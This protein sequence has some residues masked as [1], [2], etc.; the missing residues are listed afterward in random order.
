MVIDSH[1]KSALISGLASGAILI[2]ASFF[3]TGKIGSVLAK[4][5]N[6][7]LLGVFGWRS[8][9]AIA[10]LNN[11]LEGKLIPSV[12]LSLMA[13]VSVVVLALSFLAKESVSKDRL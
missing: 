8:T 10:A 6:L 11:G 4:V 5:L 2:L 13:L 3:A 7:L 9:L 1:P 12:L